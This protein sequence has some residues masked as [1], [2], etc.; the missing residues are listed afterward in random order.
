MHERSRGNPRGAGRY[1][2]GWTDIVSKF[3]AV[4]RESL[5]PENAAKLVDAVDGLESLPSLR[6]L[7][8]LLATDVQEG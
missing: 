2:I 4:V 6:S 3:G 1:P 7:S 8:S 5:S